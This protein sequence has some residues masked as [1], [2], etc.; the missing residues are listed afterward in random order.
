MEPV[1]TGN[2]V[3]DGLDMAEPLTVALLLTA[4]AAAA[5]VAA[6]EN[7]IAESAKAN[8]AVIT[9]LDNLNKPLI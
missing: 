1:V 3:E 9:W 2:T 4:F 6:T 8:S 7:N 5:T